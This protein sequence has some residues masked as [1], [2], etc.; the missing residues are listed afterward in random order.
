[1]SGARCHVVVG[2]QTTSTD[3]TTATTSVQVSPGLSAHLVPMAPSR[4]V[5][6]GVEPGR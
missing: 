5:A 1:M 6:A 4:P 2:R 3:H